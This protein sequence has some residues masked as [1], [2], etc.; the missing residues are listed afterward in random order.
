[1]NLCDGGLWRFLALRST[2]ERPSPQFEGHKLANGDAFIFVFRFDPSP[3]S[4]HSK[5]SRYGFTRPR[6]AKALSKHPTH[7][8]LTYRDT[9]TW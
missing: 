7:Q 4:V 8:P 1:M 6:T 3:R 2:P 9:D 5:I